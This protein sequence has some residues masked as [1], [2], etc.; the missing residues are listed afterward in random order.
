VNN[1]LAQLAGATIFSKIDAKSGYWQIPL[2]QVPQP[3][4]TFITPYGRYLFNKLQLLSLG[5][6]VPYS[7]E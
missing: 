5:S 7:S 4:T 6:R 1:T 3:L 2:A